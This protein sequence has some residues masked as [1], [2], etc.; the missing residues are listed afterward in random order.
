MSSLCNSTRL[1]TK[2][3]TTM[4]NCR[5]WMHALARVAR[6]A[7]A[8]SGKWTVF[9]FPQTVVFT[10]LNT[11]LYRK[12]TASDA[13]IRNSSEHATACKVETMEKLARRTWKIS[14]TKER[15]KSLITWARHLSTW[16]SKSRDQE[17]SG[18][19]DPQ[20]KRHSHQASTRK[21]HNCISLPYVRGFDKNVWNSTTQRRN[22]N[23]QHCE[24]I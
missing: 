8:E 17:R 4:A 1:T 16:P 22:T 11:T 14:N 7:G 13:N 15:K 6:R 21:S 10:E 24:I 18:E 9:T 3:E 12:P 20:G 23:L 19:E 2:K 5:F